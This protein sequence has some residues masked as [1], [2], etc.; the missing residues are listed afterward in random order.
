MAGPTFSV[1]KQLI[2]A[3]QT[4]FICIDNLDSIKANR[5]AE[6]GVNGDLVFTSLFPFK[7]T[8]SN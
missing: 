1:K 2:N 7:E 3:Y 6:K 8:G 5:K 4:K